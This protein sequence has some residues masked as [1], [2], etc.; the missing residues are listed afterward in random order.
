MTDE[1]HKGM[2]SFLGVKDRDE[3]QFLF[4]LQKAGKLLK[5]LIVNEVSQFYMLIKIL[6]CKIFFTHAF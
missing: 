5:Q 1:L 4:V 3:I 6:N 2:S